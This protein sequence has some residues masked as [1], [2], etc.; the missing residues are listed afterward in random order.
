VDAEG[1][2][3]GQVQAGEFGHGGGVDDDEVGPVFGHEHTP[4]IPTWPRL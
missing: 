1:D 4:V 3:L 2:A